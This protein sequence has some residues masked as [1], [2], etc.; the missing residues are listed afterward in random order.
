MK[1][2]LV[3]PLLVLL[4]LA[5]CAAP[6]PVAF[7]PDGRQ[8]PRIYRIA[9]DQTGQVQ[10]RMLDG[11]NTIRRAV[12]G[13]ALALNAELNAAAATHARDM[14]VQN[15]PWHFSSDGSSPIDRVARAGYRGML[16]G[17]LISE[18]FESELE[19]LAGWM[20]RAETRAIV[21]DPEAQDLGIAFFQ[22]PGGKLWWAMILGRPDAPPDFPRF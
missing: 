15:R 20:E 13:S 5:A 17:E 21:L 3:P 18:T 16:K 9:P 2:A 22:E 1:I 12:G 7:G 10:L 14:A 11:V 19:T 6:E 8:L 4:G